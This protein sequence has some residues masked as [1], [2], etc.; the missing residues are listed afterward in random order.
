MRYEKLLKEYEILLGHLVA[1]V[2]FLEYPRQ[3]YCLGLMK[4]DM[5]RAR[6]LLILEFNKQKKGEG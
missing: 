2:D 3:P 1:A 5:D 6:K 4:R